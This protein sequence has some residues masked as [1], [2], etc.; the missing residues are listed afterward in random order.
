MIDNQRRLIKDGFQ[1]FFFVFI[2][3]AH[4]SCVDKKLTERINTR[5]Q[6]VYRIR[7]RCV[8]EYR[9]RD[10]FMNK[11][12]LEHSIYLEGHFMG[13]ECMNLKNNYNM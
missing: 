6:M 9:R 2:G 13:N 5:M 12:H 4:D 11:T 10:L 3:D 8:M 1:R 7:A